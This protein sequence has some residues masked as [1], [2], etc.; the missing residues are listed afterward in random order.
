ML[1]PPVKI[2]VNSE[3]FSKFLGGTEDFQKLR[4]TP[5]KSFDG[6]ELLAIDGIL[7]SLGK[8]KL[9]SRETSVVSRKPEPT[10]KAFKPLASQI[11]FDFLGDN[12]KLKLIPRHLISA[13]PSMTYGKI[14]EL[15]NL[16]HD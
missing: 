6:N 16:I 4:G 12:E 15:I 1:E 13:P 9:D 2:L 7:T 14:P 11:T 5:P 8:F 10:A 3:P